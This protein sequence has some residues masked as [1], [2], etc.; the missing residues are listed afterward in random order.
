MLSMRA[1]SPSPLPPCDSLVSTQSWRVRNEKAG[2]TSVGG[3]RAIK[4]TDTNGYRS[5]LASP[6]TGSGPF[7]SLGRGERTQIHWQQADTER[8][9]PSRDTGNKLTLS[10]RLRVAT[11]RSALLS[12]LRL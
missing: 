9:A 7:R 2:G 11:V 12:C 8:P 10:G 1:P 6:L 3:G 4:D 5:S